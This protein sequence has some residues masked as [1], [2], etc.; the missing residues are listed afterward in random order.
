[1]TKERQ[2]APVNPG[3]LRPHGPVSP[4]EPVSSL[5]MLEIVVGLGAN[6]GDPAAAFAVAVAEL[7]CQGQVR[8]ASRLW[9]TRPLG[10]G[11]P[12]YENAAIRIGWPGSPWQL[13]EVCRE[14]EGAAGRDR[15]NEIRWGPRPLDLDL[16]IALDL[17]TR[18]PRLELP[19]PRLAERAFA[20]VPAAE[21]APDWRHPL[22]GRTLADLAAEAVGINP[23]AL[24]SNRP[25][26]IAN[27]PLRDHSQ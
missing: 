13:L 1:V 9:R 14:L 7:A 18:G 6:L 8:A 5:D 4:V 11:Q 10:P 19:H 16:L 23:D 22:L 12:D 20:L 25:F 2:S 24:I 21:V 17:V 27:H 26:E 15:Q 3:T